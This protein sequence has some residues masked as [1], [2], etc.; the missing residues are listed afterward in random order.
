MYANVVG[1]V[2]ARA[3]AARLE[4]APPKPASVPSAEP[5]SL[6][7]VARVRRQAERLARES[8]YDEAARMLTRVAER[9][10][11]VLGSEHSDVIEL[12]LDLANLQFNGGDY[13]HAAAAFQDLVRDLA[14]R[15]GPD[16][17]LV[18]RLRFQEATCYAAR[19]N[20]DL[21]LSRLEQLLSDEIRVYGRD[22]GRVTELRKQ[23]GLLQHGIGRTAEAVRGLEQLASELER[24]YGANNT[25]VREIE[26]AINGMKK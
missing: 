22:D 12:R 3:S 10:T 7:D 5:I 15:D 17:D 13:T 2:I 25:V 8:R 11:S 16:D 4:P 9:A 18:L 26:E 21:A 24:R 6:G 23:I 19:G 1:Y 14:R 20:G